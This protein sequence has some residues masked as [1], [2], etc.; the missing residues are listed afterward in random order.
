M[1]KRNYIWTLGLVAFLCAGCGGEYDGEAPYIQ[2]FEAEKIEIPLLQEQ[3]TAEEDVPE[4]EIV[5]ITV[6][7]AGDVTMGNYVGQIYA[8]SFC[9]TYEQQ[10]SDEYFLENVFD[11]FARDD[12]TLVNLEGVLTDSDAA[13]SG[14]T[15]NIKGDPKYARILTSG[16]VEAVSMANN[17]R[18]D[19][20]A[21]GTNDTVA[22][23]EE[24]GIVYAYDKN[25]GIYETKGIRI[26]YVSVNALSKSREMENMMQD[27]IVRLREENVDII[28]ACC[29]WGVEKDNYPT[30]YQQRFGKLCIDWGADLVIGHHP[31]VVQGI[32]EYK[33][34]YIAYSVGNFCFGANRN[35][36]DKDTMI[37]QQTF[38]FVD[39]EK[40]EDAVLQVI[41]CSISSMRDRNDYRPTPAKGEEAQRIIDRINS[42]SEGFGVKFD[43]NGYVITQ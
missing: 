6:S 20:G 22:A 31:H 15:Y 37:L 24:E 28:L 32:E 25:I 21:K 23:L 11:I 2:S 13:S 10:Q 42:Y 19:F 4:P 7:A 41:P 29:H 1:R 38:T 26:G 14:R 17:H 3:D 30:D 16:S 36:A 8:Y 5:T 40:Q 18:L 12:M 34:R 35:P 33:G 39:G 9:E 27:G 43:E